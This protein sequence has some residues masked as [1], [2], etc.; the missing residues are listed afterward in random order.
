MLLANPPTYSFPPIPAPPATCKA[1]VL[2]DVA[3]VVFVM[4]IWDDVVPLN[5]PVAPVNPC[6]PWLPV[7]PCIAVPWTPWLPV[8]PCEVPACPCTP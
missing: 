5:E 6:T 2:V 7:V 8:V 4:I 3:E 1:P